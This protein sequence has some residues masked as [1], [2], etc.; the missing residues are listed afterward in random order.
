MQGLALNWQLTERGAKLIEKTKSAKAY[1]MFVIEGAIE[2]PGMIRDENSGSDIE[3]EIW[4]VPKSEFGSFVAAIPGPLGIGKVETED[5]R[6]LPGFI[7]E[8]YAIENAQEVTQLG[9]WR[10][11][12]E[13]IQ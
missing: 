2:R 1:R 6:W 10:S 8:G 4:Q 5:G 13:K 7:C 12:I 3:I 11:Y 9:G